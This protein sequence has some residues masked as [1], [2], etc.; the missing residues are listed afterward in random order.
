M[1]AGDFS[2]STLLNVQV[3]ADRMFASGILGT[4]TRANVDALRTLLNRQSGV[5]FTP[6]T[7]NS[8]V[9]GTHKRLAVKAYWLKPN[10]LEAVT[11]DYSC[12][13][14]GTEAETGG[15]VYSMSAGE[16]VE[17]KLRHDDFATNEI[18]YQEAFAHQL[19]MAEKALFEKLT[20]KFV[21]Q[22]YAKR[23]QLIYPDL[24][25]YNATTKETELAGSFFA[26]ASAV[27]TM[28]HLQV[29]AIYNKLDNP[30]LL[31]GF[32]FNQAFL[33]N[34]IN[35]GNLDGKGA[36]LAT[37]LLPL[38]WDLYNIDDSA[39]DRK[40]FMIN[41]GSYGIAMRNYVLGEK[42]VGT[43]KEMTMRSRLFPNVTLDV[44]MDTTCEATLGR[45]V[46]NV[47]ISVAGDLF[48]NP[49]YTD[50]RTGIYVI[51]NTD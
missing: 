3:R 13:I 22:L 5:T 25:T 10:E 15:Q 1:A 39:T 44:F 42:M 16:K 34:Q 23:G 18:G 37:T 48:V 12:T 7:D 29:A 40:T 26:G 45:W 8:N 9:G 6:L 11:D 4:H 51:R 50:A 33:A 32:N 31:S 46:D 20:A 2:A 41:S 49:Y 38:E 43:K 17:F 35:A 14:D 19:L 24:G 27:E 47:R 28:T 21:G 30:F 36:A